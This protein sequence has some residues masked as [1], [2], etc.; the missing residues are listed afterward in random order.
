MPLIVLCG[1]PCSGKSTRAAELRESLQ[2]STILPIMI[3]SDNDLFQTDSKDTIYADTSKEKNLR[4]TIKSDVH[5]ALSKEVVVIMDAQNY[6]KGYRYEVY[7]ITKSAKTTQCTVWCNS[8]ISEAKTWNEARD[9]AVRYSEATFDALVMRFEPPDSA[10]RWENPLFTLLPTDPLPITE[11]LEVLINRRAPPPNQSTQSQPLAATNY[12]HELDKITQ[13]IVAAVISAQQNGMIGEKIV[14]TGST[15][16]L[17]LPKRILPA[18]LGRLRRQFISYSRTRPV[19][20][21]ERIPTIFI[22][23][24]KNS[25]K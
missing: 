18:E 10:N 22:Q 9:A 7:C 6:I 23:Y 2:K 21:L 24:L 14:V 8:P 12:L 13:E 17:I 11:L 1:L 25:I 3:V 4:A 19:D 20:S 5:R 16:P 15:E